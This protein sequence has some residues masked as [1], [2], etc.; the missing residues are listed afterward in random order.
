MDASSVD[1]E[2]SKLVDAQDENSEL[3]DDSDVSNQGDQEPD[4][5]AD[6]PWET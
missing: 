5:W 3:I 1:N 4:E 2:D 6:E